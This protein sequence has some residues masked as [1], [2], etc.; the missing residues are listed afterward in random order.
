[1]AAAAGAGTDDIPDIDEDEQTSGYA[2]AY[3]QLHFASAPEVDPYPGEAVPSFMIG[4][5]A[6]LNATNPGVLPAV[7]TKIVQALP[8]EKQA[9]RTLTACSLP[10]HPAD[11]PHLI[12]CIAFIARQHPRTP[13]LFTLCDFH[14]LA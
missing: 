12:T 14:L 6:R 11:P 10:P 2:A 4:S 1:M 7:V 9:R 5:L 8:A 13:S 3:A